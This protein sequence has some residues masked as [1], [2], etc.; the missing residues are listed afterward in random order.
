MQG[1]LFK[2]HSF[3]SFRVHIFV[4]IILEVALIAGGVLSK[5]FRDKVEVGY[6]VK[7]GK[8]YLV[9]WKTDAKEQF[10]SEEHTSELQSH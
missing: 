3:E 6:I 9:Y 1:W 2:K 4:L 10:R 7:Q 8:H 5:N